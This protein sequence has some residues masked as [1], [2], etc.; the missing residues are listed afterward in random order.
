MRNNEITPASV[1]F[2]SVFKAVFKDADDGT[3]TFVREDDRVFM[4]YHEQD[5]CEQVYIESITGDLA[6]LVGTPLLKYEE[7][8]SHDRPDDVPPDRDERWNNSTTW[9]FYKFA[10]IKGYVDVRWLGESNGYYS[11]AV[12]FREVKHD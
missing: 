4:F 8:V 3:L 9:T 1:L 11:E 6:D 5:C 10:T 12:S 2:G 7:A